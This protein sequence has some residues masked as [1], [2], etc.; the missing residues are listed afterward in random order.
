M[1]GGIL[2]ADMTTLARQARAGWDWWR[3][4]L[5]ELVPAAWRARLPRRAGVVATFDGVDAFALSRR[6]QPLTAR[7]QRRPVAALVA[8]PAELCLVRETSLPIVGPRDLRQLVALSQERL[9]PFPAGAALIDTLVISRDAAA[10]RQQVAVAAL[11]RTTADAAIAAAA[12]AGI[13]PTG[14]GV[15]QPNGT[16]SF[17]FLSGMD[18]AGASAARA[19][20]IWW[21]AVAVLLA[22]N[23]GALVGGDISATGQLEALVAEHGQAAGLARAVRQR[24]V[25]EEARRY[26]LVDR[27][28]VTDPLDLLAD[29]TRLIPATAWV[30]RLGWDGRQLR[31][32][33]YKQ[34]AT[35]LMAALR[36]SPRLGAARPTSGEVAATTSAGEPF[37]ITVDVP[38]RR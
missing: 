31:L 10:G 3:H 16:V 28:A 32:S 37:D 23:L 20:R 2:D 33:G 26:A 36:R 34:G 13:A 30:E 8:I 18:G 6:G 29:L 35:D 1:T 38:V 14:F 21:A 11:P 7:S 27:R 19:R 24:V 5:A 17:D 15:T 25:R 4:E 22:L 9:M 12:R